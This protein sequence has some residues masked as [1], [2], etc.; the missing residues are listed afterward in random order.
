MCTY[1]PESEQECEVEK[2][3][4]VARREVVDSNTMLEPQ[5]CVVMD[6]TKKIS[7]PRRESKDFLVAQTVNGLEVPW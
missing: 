3:T 7:G 1:K 5:V 2:K 4:M 6:K